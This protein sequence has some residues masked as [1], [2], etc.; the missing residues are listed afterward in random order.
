MSSLKDHDDYLAK[1]EQIQDADAAR[2]DAFRQADQDRRALFE[3]VITNYKNLTDAHDGLT[4]EIQVAKYTNQALINDNKALKAELDTVK[5]E[6]VCTHIFFL[7][8][9]RSVAILDH[10]KAG[11]I[12]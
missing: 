12:F 7:P 5:N 4:S 8:Y 9:S 3:E 10:H 2:L 6:Q 11:N 1:L